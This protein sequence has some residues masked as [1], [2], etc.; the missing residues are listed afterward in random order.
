MDSARLWQ[1][2]ETRPRV[3]GCCPA[4]GYVLIAAAVWLVVPVAGFALTVAGELGAFAALLV[5]RSERDADPYRDFGELPSYPDGGVMDAWVHTFD[6][7][8]S[9]T[10]HTAVVRATRT[11]LFALLAGC[12]ALALAGGRLAATGTLAG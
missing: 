5:V 6:P 3:A 4:V 2:V 7:R 9:E 12:I 1:F 10:R 8:P 11:F